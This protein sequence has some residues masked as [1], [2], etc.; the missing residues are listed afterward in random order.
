M[1]KKLVILFL[2]TIVLSGMFSMLNIDRA[3]ASSVATTNEIL[4][5]HYP[6]KL[7][8]YYGENFDPTGMEVLGRNN[9]GTISVITDYTISGFDNSRLGNQIL[10]IRYQDF[11]LNI[12]V[13][14]KLAPITGIA[15]A[16]RSL[17]TYTLTWSSA[18][19]GAN[20]EVYRK[21]EST[22]ISSLVANVQSNSYAVTD[23]SGALYTYQI[24]IV[25]L[26]D[27]ITYYGE[28]SDPFQ[29]TTA[30]DKVGTL[31][32]IKTTDTTVNLSWG[33]VSGATGYSIYRKAVGTAD[34]TY[35]G[36]TITANYQDTKLKSGT[37]YIYKVSAFRLNNTFY[38]EFSP[39]LEVSTNPAKVSIRTKAG[40]KKARISWSPVTGATSYEIYYGDEMSGYTLLTTVAAKGV[41]SYIEEGLIT[42]ITY[43]YSVIA[44]K[45]YNGIVYTGLRSDVKPV[46]IVE[47]IATSTQAKYFAD[48]AA[49]KASTAYNKIKFFKDNVKYKQSYIIPGLVNTNVGGF[50][51]TTMIPQSIIFAGD[52]LLITAYDQ[53]DEELSVVYV[54]DKKSKELLTTLVLPTDAH[55]GGICT[56]G[57]NIYLTTGSRV[58]V[59]WYNDIVAAVAS[60]EPSVNI[61]FHSDIK[62]GFS[63]SYI[64][65]YHDKIWVGSYNELKTTK[66]YSYYVDDFEDYITLTKA[67][68]VTMPTRV[69]GIAFT[70]DGYMIISRSCQLYKGLRGYM[71][72]IDVYLP[73]ISEEDTGSMDLGECIKYEYVPSMNEGIAIDGKYLYV[74]YE[75]AAFQNA[76][77]KVD[78]ISAFELK[79]ILP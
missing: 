50:Q 77:Y 38:G 46:T 18:G 64:A 78:R 30:P 76:S 60:G 73:E 6:D 68:A 21:D 9:D 51:S 14:V 34:Y 10:T 56:D 31:S 42:G 41:N 67:D 79:K 7:V 23:F 22:G 70:E 44:K 39:L 27:G 47:G 3:Q 69:Q 75:S 28:F 33:M 72:R 11:I 5:S 48:E 49:F 45:E 36:D 57:T 37:G 71:R 54:M 4:L 16:N 61:N 2:V 17:S 20:Y 8:Y 53:A 15:V 13:Q 24:R 58:S 35:V 12:T 29:A 74:L 59:F 43:S 63:C 1:N 26:I 52:Y 25:K 55:V 19:D 32:V 40:V 62:V 65:F 66:L